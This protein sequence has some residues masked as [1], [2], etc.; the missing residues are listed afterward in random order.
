MG[1]SQALDRVGPRGE[2]PADDTGCPILHVDMDAFYASVELRSRP[3]LR[4][5]PVIVGGGER[6]VVLSATYEAR[7]FGVRSAMPMSR[8]RR[9]CPQAVVLAPGFADYSEVSAGVMA[10]FRSV[11]PLVQPLSLDEAFLDVSGA[12]RRFGSGAVRPASLVP[13]SGPDVQGPGP[14]RPRDEDAWR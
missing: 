5:K 7:T 3:D 9:L 11:T 8:A 1:R 10:V 13:L 12:V 14:P 2:P 4:G 6:G